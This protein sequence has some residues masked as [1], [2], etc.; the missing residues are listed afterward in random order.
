M[1]PK[2]D[3]ITSNAMVLTFVAPGPCACAFQGGEKRAEVTGS[4]RSGRRMKFESIEEIAS[5]PA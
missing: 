3:V 2:E 1:T 5:T 4:N